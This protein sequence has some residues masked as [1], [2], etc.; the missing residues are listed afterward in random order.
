MGLPTLVAST[1]RL[2]LP[3][4]RSHLPMMVSDSPPEWPGTQRE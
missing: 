4:W 2:R 3:L 1:T